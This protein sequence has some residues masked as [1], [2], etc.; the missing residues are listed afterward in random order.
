MITLKRVVEL[1]YQVQVRD[2][3]THYIS[4]KYWS[5]PNRLIKP[6]FDLV[7]SRFT[8]MLWQ[9]PLCQLFRHQNIK[10]TKII[11]FQFWVPFIIYMVT[12]TNRK[13][14][15]ITFVPLSLI[16]TDRIF[17]LA[18]SDLGSS[19]LYDSLWSNFFDICVE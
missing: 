9:L 11:I 17:F 5:N 14:Y 18:G 6:I 3:R 16:W 10:Q 4:E 19:M 12:Y 13:I 15:R 2:R 8:L 7:C 1:T